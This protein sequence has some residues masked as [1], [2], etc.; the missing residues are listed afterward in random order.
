MNRLIRYFGVAAL[1]AGLA[2]AQAPSGEG[3]QKGVRAH[4]GQGRVMQELGLTDAQRAQAKEIFQASRKEAQPIRQQ[5]REARQ[6]LAADLKAGAAE[7]VISQDANA[8]GNLTAQLTLIHAKSRQQ[9][10]SILTAE[11]KAKI[12]EMRQNRRGMRGQRRAG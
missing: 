3:R 12:D 2:V 10:Q 7:G 11:Q 6:R 9:F 1:A 8:I 4:R 5:L